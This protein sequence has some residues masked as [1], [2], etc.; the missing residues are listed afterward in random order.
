MDDIPVASP[1]SQG[2]L[3]SLEGRLLPVGQANVDDASLA[4]NERRRVGNDQR[5]TIVRL[6]NEPEL[7][8][9]H[10]VHAAL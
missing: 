3:A 4:C 9:R 1:R 6:G 5:L 2:D 7:A 8:G 10:E